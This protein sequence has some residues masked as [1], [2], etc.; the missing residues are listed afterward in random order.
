MRS[1]VLLL[2]KDTNI[3]L[4]I[5][6]PDRN[7]VITALIASLRDRSGD[8]SGDVRSAA[9]HALAVLAKDDKDKAR[10]AITALIASLRDR[11]GDPSGDVRSAAAQALAVLA[12]DDKDKAREAST[13]LI[14]SL[15]DHNGQVISAAAQAL[16][17]LAKDDKDKAREAITALIAS[18][19]DPS[20][21]F[22]G[23]ARSAAAQAL[24]VLAKDDKDKAREASTALIASLGDPSGDLG[25]YVRS[26]AAQALAV[27]AKDDKD[28]AREAITALIASLGDPSGDLG[29]YVRSAAAQ[30]L[31]VLAK[32]D[33]DKAR[34]ASTALIASLRDPSGDFRGDA[35]S[36]AAQALAVLA[37]DD[38]D[39]AR[40]A[41]TALIASLRD[42][43]GDPS[44]DVR[45]A[46]AQALAVLAK[47]DKD[48]AREAITALIAS[49]GDP[50][51]DSFAIPALIQIMPDPLGATHIAEL[52]GPAMD[53][54]QEAGR[55]EAEFH[56]L[57]GGDDTSA[58]L[59]PVLRRAQRE[60][61][62][63]NSPDKTLGQFLVIW[64]FTTPYRELRRQI[65]WHTKNI[66]E[67]LC[68]QHAKKSTIF[69]NELPKLI[70]ILF[71]TLANTTCFT[72][73]ERNNIS[74]LS[75]LFQDAMLPE[76][77][78]LDRLLKE[79]DA[80]DVFTRIIGWGLAGVA[81]H[82]GLWV[83]LLC[84]YP[85]YVWVQAVFFWN[86]TVRKLLGLH[87]TWL[88]PLI[89]F[90]RRRLLAPFRS[91]FGPK[92]A[93]T[94]ALSLANTAWFPD[95][96]VIDVATQT[97]M[98]ITVALP[99]ITGLTVLEGGSGLGKTVYL[100][101]LA[102]APSFIVAFLK[103]GEEGG[104]VVKAIAA[105]FPAD[106]MR[107]EAFL[108]MLIHARG[109]DICIDGLNEVSAE[110]RAAVASFAQAATKANILISTQPI[111][112]NRPAGTR[113]LRLQPLRPAQRQAFLESREPILS[114]ISTFRGENF[115][116]RVKEFIKEMETTTPALI[117]ERVARER[118]LSN[119]MDL[120][121]IALI[122]ANDGTPDLLNLQRTVY[123]QAAAQYK[124]DNQDA[125]F[126]LTA[127]SE[128]IYQLRCKATGD[129]RELILLRD[130]HFASE[131]DALAD[132]RL[133]LRT[134]EPNEEGKVAPAW[135]FRHDKVLDFFL[136]TALTNR[137][138]MRERIAAHVGDPRFAGV[139]LLLALRAPLD[140]ARD[141][142]DRLND[143]ATE[144]RDHALADEVWGIVRQRLDTPSLAEAE[145]VC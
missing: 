45:S 124:A 46:A 141:M 142:R 100:E 2:V 83:A 17:V 63:Y 26:A 135:R 49:L 59:L 133:L 77:H 20:G 117:E 62:K 96:E 25:G 108:R 87:L 140:V 40:E 51:G 109:L 36:A 4:E 10:E 143:H 50:R 18:L 88:I 119:P 120:T 38:K 68:I 128:H 57:T 12:K 42:R 144:T 101:R 125:E 93:S 92:P 114:P 69:G 8:P 89:P 31:A 34:E 6:P 90:A 75:R 14:A 67:D 81:A 131:C 126:P 70:A 123:L 132:Y 104:D 118:A 47:D 44:G 23:D 53:W 121:T 30:A 99:R 107:D 32:D 105:R 98:P 1:E 84:L 95:A 113:L 54:P 80:R 13:A 60:T 103:A 29:G 71:N 66:T 102:R 111:R 122:L 24:A 48:K 43:S 106:I 55:I 79:D 11:S 61:A 112:W 41:I 139:Y 19:R 72:S 91:A 56:V 3:P 35:R 39:K 115:A 110:A 116:I 94:G 136:Y 27:L 73:E 97:C 9:A 74:K 138:V 65:A 76:G 86:P 82:F 16:A 21:D 37:K 134:E 28:K 129:E 78:D 64:P 137:K 22:R 5:F 85:R 33:K 52:I 130:Q 58:L 15:R 7:E 127:F 145:R